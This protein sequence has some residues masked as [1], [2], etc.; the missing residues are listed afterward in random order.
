[1]RKG[2]IFQATKRYFCWLSVRSAALLSLTHT[3]FIHPY[4]TYI[5]TY[6]HAYIHSFIHS[7]IRSYIHVKV[8][9]VL[10]TYVFV[11]VRP[12]QFGGQFT[13][14]GANFAI[15]CVCSGH[16]RSCL[17]Y[18]SVILTLFCSTLYYSR[19]NDSGQITYPG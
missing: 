10:A 17:L 4:N 1:M 6:I 12:Y 13:V 8:K 19:S 16:K 15:F 3:S 7:F 9:A 11:Q 14:Y 5:H 2:T 18:V